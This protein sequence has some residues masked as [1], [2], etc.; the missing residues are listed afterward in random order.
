MPC[1]HIKMPGGATAIICTGRAR[2]RRCSVH[3]CSNPG[4]RQCDAKV[5][6]KTCDK[7][8]CTA[9]AVHVR[10]KDIDYCPDHPEVRASLQGSLAL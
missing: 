9:H 7:Y 4:E 1:E 10:G 5:D 3:G 8:L 6:G 2:R